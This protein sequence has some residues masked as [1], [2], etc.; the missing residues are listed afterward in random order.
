MADETWEKIE[1]TTDYY[2]SDMGRVKKKNKLVKCSQNK[3]GYPSCWIEVIEKN[4]KT[5]KR[6]TVHRL[7]ANAFIPNPENKPV[8]DH[9]SGD[10]TDNTVGNL[11]WTTVRENTQAAHDIG[12]IEKTEVVAIDPNEFVFL[13]KTQADASKDSGIDRK[14]VNQVIKGMMHSAKGW[15]FFRM[16]KLTDK[17]GRSK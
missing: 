3:Y 8:V 4:T 1:G 11:R 15:R 17:R 13:Y 10:K 5:R 9:I 16:R 12:L 14:T 7:V 2:I 6:A